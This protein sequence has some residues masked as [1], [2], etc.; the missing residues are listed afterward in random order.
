[1]TH[2]RFGFH[3]AGFGNVDAG[4]SYIA[5]CAASNRP[6]TV[7]AVDNHNPALW[8]QALG[9]PYDVIGFRMTSRDGQ[10]LD[11]LDYSTDP[12]AFAR[13]RF[14]ATANYWPTELDPARVWTTPCNEP[15]K[16]PGEVGWL[17]TFTLEYARLSIER[18]RRFAAYGW[19]M[20]TPEP[21]FWRMASTLEYLRLCAQRPD[22]LAINI[23]EYSGTG[24]LRDNTPWLIGRFGE[25]HAACDEIGLARPQ[26]IIGEFGWSEANIRPSPD[27]FESQIRWAQDLY[28][29]HA[30]VKGAAIWTLGTW[31]GSVT[32]DLAGHMPTLAALVPQF[33][34]TPTDPPPQ[35]PASKPKIVIVKKPQKDAMTLAENETASRWAWDNYGR[36]ATHS[37][38]DMMTM[39]AAGNADSYAVIAYPS[40]QADDI[41]AL[42]ARGYRWQPMVGIAP[43]FTRLAVPHLSQYGSGADARSNDCGAACVAMVARLAGGTPTVDEVALAYQSPPNSYMSFTQ[44]DAALNGYGMDGTY[45]RPF[46]PQ[47][48]DNGIE[49]GL[50]SICLVWYQALPQKFSTFN[51]A[52][53]I[54]VYGTDGTNSLLYRD[55]LAPDGRELAIT[56]AQ[57]SA[58]MSAV[59]QG[60]QLANQ[61]MVCAVKPPPAATV[62]LL[63]YLRGN[64]TLYEV[65]HPSGAQERFQTQVAGNEFY[66]VKNSQ[67]EALKSDGD[68]IWRGLDT[69]PG[70]APVYAER[71][72]AMRYYR[73]YEAGQSWAR[74][75]KRHMAA[76][77]TYTGPGHHVQFHYKSD[78]ALSAAN[79]GDAVN[80]VTLVRLHATKTWNGI[81]C[82]DVAELTNG[83]ERFWF[84]RGLGLVA[85]QSSWGESAVSEIHAPGTRPNNVREVG[86]W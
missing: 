38:D 2:F 55:P 1:M 27:G 26:I 42:E 8:V 82:N 48:A 4:Q 40:R 41:A 78:C 56:F 63:P 60:G 25:L 6:A 31:H 29:Q 80:R 76:G 17:A 49:Y 62:D 69:S 73:Q 54:A 10:S 67:Y 16:E 45:A 44:I 11:L 35:P 57:L 28:G 30:N 13:Q 9:R 37:T 24:N 21:F 33:P 36:T 12:V 32:S 52:H 15:S 83:A 74:W 39:L 22:L 65:R 86:C 75:C 77:E 64:G 51:G 81:T 58:A 53:F 18:G 59:T 84:A 47:D 70:P 3:G 50:P 34:F 19:S 68:F 20:G 7:F 85:W 71:P 66:L 43:V 61:G 46:L 5:A 72:G 79:S 23:H 14:A